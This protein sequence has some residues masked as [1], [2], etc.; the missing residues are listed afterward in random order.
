MILSMT[1]FAAKSREV[2]NGTLDFELRSINSRYLDI[3]LRLG[4]DFRAL[5]PALRELLTR[6]LS[7]GKIEC[8]LNFSAAP[9]SGNKAELNTMLL[10]QLADFDRKVRA[11]APEAQ[12]LSCGE[13]LRWPGMLCDSNI[14]PEAL[15]PHCLELADEALIDLIDTRRREGAKLAAMIYERLTAMRA[16]VAN[17]TPLI[18]AAQAAF[19]E[20]LRQKLLESLN[21][22]DDERIKQEVALYAARIDVA[23][24]LSRLSTHLDEVERI[25]RT[26][27]TSGKRLDFLMQELNREANTLGSKSGTS[28][29]TATAMELKLYIEQIREQAQNIE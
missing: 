4:D 6:R 11:K 28:E 12:P 20:K 29:T 3:Y 26:G 14:Q 25:L 9:D 16:L 23:E 13:Y 2:D 8:R 17:I 5:E 22:E 21:L 27:G 18:P 1:G 7:R 19:E 24:E 15:F 10:E